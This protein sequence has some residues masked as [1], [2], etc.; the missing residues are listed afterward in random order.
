MDHINRPKYIKKIERFV[1][2]PIIKDK[3]LKVDEKYYLTD[4]GFRQARGYT[5]TI[6]KINNQE[7]DF[8]AKINN[9]IN[10]FQVSYLMNDEK[11]R[12]R[13]FGALLEIKDNFPKYVLS[14]DNFDFSQNGIIHKNL[15]G[16]LL[17]C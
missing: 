7:I 8:I 17:D 5:V 13:E 14:L 15:I 3:I 4:Y 2:K 11:T 12:N 1:D 16:F 10:Y 6:G 9:E